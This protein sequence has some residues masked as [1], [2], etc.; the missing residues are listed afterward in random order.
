MT[1]NDYKNKAE[2]FCIAVDEFAN[3]KLNNAED[4]TRLTEIVFKLAKESQL[5][6]LSFSA[7]Y[8]TGLL[9]IIQSRNN[10][11]EDDYFDKI[12]EEYTQTVKKVRLQLEDLLNDATPFIKNIYQDKFLAMTHE[13][14]NNLNLLMSDLSWTKMY[15]NDTK[16]SVRD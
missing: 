8:A 10:N 2:K 5:E 4:L 1:E 11:F 15:L 9:K 6:E 14:L 13:S 16:R 3:G 7:K 12:K